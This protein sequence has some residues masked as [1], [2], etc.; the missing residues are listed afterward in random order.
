MLLK[1]QGFIYFNK[2]RLGIYLTNSLQE[3][4]TIEDM[5]GGFGLAESISDESKEASRIKKEKPIMVV[6]GNPPY[7]GESSNKGKNFKWIDS[8][9]DDYKK[10][11]GGLENLTREIQSGLMMIM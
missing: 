9:L 7:S 4:N 1:E 10:E 11:P 8:L 2:A 6:L 5:F 3:G